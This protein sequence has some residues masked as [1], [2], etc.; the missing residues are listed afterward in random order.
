MPSGAETH[1]TR[2]YAFG[3]F[4]LIPDRQSLLR[5]DAVVA[6]GGRALDILAALVERPGEIVPK[7]QLIARAWPDTH[8]GESNLKVNMNALRRALGEASDAP[9][10]IA[11]VVGRGYR[12]I[13]PVAVTDAPVAPI[14]DAER[15]PPHN[16][17]TAT[18]H[19]HGRDAIRA[20]VRDELARSRLVTI[21]GPGGAGKTTLALAVAEDLVASFEAGVWLVDL[22]GI[23]DP[24]LVPEAIA[25]AVR[26]STHAEDRIAALQSHLRQRRTLLVLDNC[27]HV[28]EA[29]ASAA[30]RILAATSAV[31]ILATSRE[32]LRL[33]GE[34][35]RRLGGLDV[36]AET[37]SLTAAAALAFPAVTLFVDRVGDRVDTFVLGDAE[38]PAAAEICRRLDGLPLAIEL[39]A[40]H[41]EAFGVRA[42]LRHLERQVDLPSAPRG[43]L[44]RHRTL[45]DVVEWSTQLLPERTRTVLHR[46]SVFAGPFGVSDAFAVARDEAGDAGD[47][48]EAVADLVAKSLLSTEMWG[49]GIAYR[50]LHTTRGYCRRKL[51]DSGE[52]DAAR[53]RHAGHVAAVLERAAIEWGVLPAGEWAR[54]Y[55]HALDDLRAAL[56]WCGTV[57]GRAGLLVRLTVAGSLLWNHFSLTGECRDRVA[58]AIAALPAVG[59]VGSAEEMKLQMSFAGTTLFTRGAVPDAMAALK[60]VLPIAEAIGDVDHRL[61]CLRTMGS[62]ELFRG[63]PATKAEALRRFRAIAETEDPTALPAGDAH[64]ALA[65]LFMGNLP[66]ARRLL[67]P[68]YRR[69]PAE[70]RDPRFARFLFDQNVDIGNVLSHVEWLSGRPDTALRLTAETVA[71]AQRMGH[72]LSLSN[73]LAW[74]C[75]TYLLA[76]RYEDCAGCVEALEEQVV[77]HG[78][79]IWRPIATICRGALD[80]AEG[81][82]VAALATIERAMAEFAAIVH[83]ARM[84]FYLGIKSEALA[85]AGR[86]A[87]AETAA[88][89]ALDCAAAQTENW[90]RPE[91]LR[92]AGGVALL[93]GHALA[94]ERLLR[95]AMAEAARF[96][97]RSF[98]LRAANDLCALWLAEGRGA[99][100][101]PILRPVVSAFAKDVGNPDLRRAATLLGAAGADAG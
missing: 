71:L 8:I 53:E 77:R 49:D 36:P 45:M 3:P 65:E 48:L 42:L 82:P 84:P 66:D 101:A 5:D 79:V 81:S 50:L 60:R 93:Q 68:H 19:L 34:R 18:T 94:A 75:L 20:A 89:A 67:L 57:P 7:R 72:E 58:R 98:E 1:P 9:R 91:L 85:R 13:A 33:K 63:N 21:A 99:E 17:P 2:V 16:L 78:I 80:S 29:A 43:G 47:T 31:R 11:T 97:A 73:A 6:V 46:L 4:R 61:R 86:L 59:L 24:A 70:T 25:A 44:D 64:L 76:R 35:V 95:E 69:D 28:V 10:Y 92:I 62:Y 54:R 23:R 39:A 100:M 30:E 90:I 41:V 14:V 88:R 26:L 40:P 32:P 96:G 74:A 52:E 83:R 51:R 56:D 55:G 38:A 87:D 15:T 22:T 27:E 37:P 12:F